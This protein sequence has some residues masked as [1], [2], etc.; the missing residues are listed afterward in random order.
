MWVHYNSFVNW[1]VPTSHFVLLDFSCS[2]TILSLNWFLMDQLSAWPLSP[3]SVLAGLGSYLFL[4]QKPGTASHCFQDI[5][6]KVCWF[7][8]SLW[9]AKGLT[10]LVWCSSTS[11]ASSLTLS[12]VPTS[13]TKN[14]PTPFI[15]Q[16][17]PKAYQKWCVKCK[18]KCSHLKSTL[19]ML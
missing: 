13:G 14:R 19:K 3:T 11:S 7:K 5:H 15:T 17:V 18:M 10:Q 1:L 8:L 9:W 12:P 2:Y 4:L 6:L 16:P